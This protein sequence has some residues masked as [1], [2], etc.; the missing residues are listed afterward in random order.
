MATQAKIVIKGQNDVSQAVKSAS[1]D[2][3]GLKDSD[4]KSVV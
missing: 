2:L 3:S 4:R 1:Q